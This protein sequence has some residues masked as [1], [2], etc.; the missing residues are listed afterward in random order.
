MTTQWLTTQSI[1]LKI[2]N[3]QLSTEIILR[4]KTDFKRIPEIIDFIFMKPYYAVDELS[5]YLDVHRNTA[6]SYLAKLVDLKL[7]Y[8]IKIWRNKFFFFKDYYD[9]LAKE[10]K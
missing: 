2:R 5:I 7:I 8:E 1:V 3:L 9:L 4:K 6:S 10:S